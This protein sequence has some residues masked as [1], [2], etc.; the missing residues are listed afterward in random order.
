[1]HLVVVVID[2]VV[3]ARAKRAQKGRA[4]SPPSP[5]LRGR[6]K[7]RE[8]KGEYRNMMDEITLN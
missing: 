7:G 8:G 1:M 3:L 6:G 4:C 2:G 5:S